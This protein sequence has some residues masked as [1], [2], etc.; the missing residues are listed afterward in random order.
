VDHTG[1]IWWGHLDGGISTYDGGRFTEYPAGEYRNGHEVR[2]LVE[3]RRGN[4]W[5]GINGAGMFLLRASVPER[6][7]Q[8]VAYSPRD[9]RAVHYGHGRMWVGSDNGL[10]VTNVGSKLDWVE[11]DPRV[12]SGMAITALWED[13]DGRFWIGSEENGLFI[14]EPAM[15]ARPVLGLPSAPIEDVIGDGQG[16]IWVGTRGDGLWRFSETLEESRVTGL[17][18]FSVDD[19]L[20][21]NQVREFTIDSEGNV[22]FALFGGG[23]ASYIC[24]PFETT[25]HSDNPLLLGVWSVLEDRQGTIWLGT[26]GGLVRLDP[27]DTT[28]RGAGA[29]ELTVDDGLPHESVRALHEDPEGYLWL[30]TKG[31]GLARFHPGTQAID[32]IGFADGLPTEA[33]L[34]LKGGEAKEIWIGTLGQGVVRYRP[35]EDGDFGRS[36]GTFEHYPLL[37]GEEGA[38]VYAIFRDSEGTIWAAA[39]SMGVAEFVPG[40]SAGERGRFVIHGEEKGLA[41]LELNSIAEDHDGLLWVAASDGGLYTFDGERFTDVSKG[42]ALEDEHVYLVACDKRNTILAG[43]NYGLYR[44]DREAQRFTF[45]G[46][47]EGF[48]GIETNVNASFTD[49]EGHVWFGTINGATHYD[50]DAFRANETPPLTH[51]TGLGVFLEPTELAPGATFN[52]SQNHLTFDFIG[53]SMTAPNAVRYQYMLEGLD[54]NWLA[55][56]EARSATY[57]NLPPGKYTFK[58]RASNSSGVWSSNPAEYRFSVRAPYWRAGWFYT[59][60]F[61]GI[62][63]TI[64]GLHRW[65]TRA[66]VLANRHLEVKVDERTAELSR[67]SKELEE[68]NEALEEALEQA[69]AGAKAKGAFLAN[70]SHEIRTPMNGVVGMTDLLLESGL[71][72]EQHEYAETV[73]KSADALLSILNDI[74]DFSK[75]EA[76]KVGLEPIPFDLRVSL[77]EVTDLLAPRIQDR[78]VELIVRYDAVTP[79][80]FIGDAGRIRQIITNLVGNA[81]KFTEEGHVLIGVE[82]VGTVGEKAEIRVSVEDTG[83]GIPEDKVDQVFEKFTQ[84]DVSATRRF[85][86]TGLGLSISRQLVE[87]MDGRIAVESQEGV[88]STFSFVIPLPVCERPAPQALPSADLKGVRGLIVDDNQ[89]NR[90]LLYERLTGWGARADAVESAKEALHALRIAAQAGDPYVIAIIDYQMPHMDGAELGREIRRDPVLAGTVMLMLTSVG[91]QGDAQRLKEIGFAGYLLKPVRFSQLYGMLVT[92]WG[93]HE[94]GQTL[95]FVTRHTLAESGAEAHRPPPRTA[96][97]GEP[98]PPGTRTLVAEDNVVNQR[99]AK[100]I[101]EKLGCSVDLAANGREALEKLENDSYDVVFMDCQMPEMDGYEATREIRRRFRGRGH[102]PVIAMTAHAMPGDRER[103]LE[104]GMDD[105][106]AKPVRPENFEAVL[107]RWCA[108]VASST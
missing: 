7:F 72:P 73:R 33:L 48:W 13:D 36:K 66:F 47:D 86:G 68:T 27:S 97:A 50:P 98:T 16:W 37:V 106:I 22:W 17:K 29:R 39:D 24:G 23:I 101:L 93:A 89:I 3:D 65:R 90:K 34:S 42:S 82:C 19:G 52:Y 57:S 56:T 9:V 107:D 30:A 21:Y 67:R 25:R 61:F 105:Y 8:P 51:I 5:A 78:N 76:G 81:L 12:L 100:A 44:Y 6:G 92:I 77:E 80:R 18:T 60:C 103:C 64:V 104:A 63:G 43:T 10:W 83:I 108:G 40:P 59:L 15:A 74:L 84:A 46:R 91:R 4:I 45:Y 70:M 53:I 79:R 58:V 2:A 102:V 14:R 32:V 94:R 88:G 28:R 75:I 85:G 11:V 20:G 62:L 38:D 1:R 96:P 54:R 71:T 69:E 55:P 26:D 49:S 87:M 35:P 95:D 41:H 31:G 99:L